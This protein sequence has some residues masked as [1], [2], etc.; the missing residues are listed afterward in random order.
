VKDQDEGNLA[1][2]KVEGEKY[3]ENILTDLYQKAVQSVLVEGGSQLMHEFIS[4]GYWDE[5]RVFKSTKI[6]GEGIVAPRISGMLV[7]ETELPEGDRL[8]VYQQEE[9]LNI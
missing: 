7:S 6:F 3:L 1:F 2:V 4:Q 8:L 9:I 5:I